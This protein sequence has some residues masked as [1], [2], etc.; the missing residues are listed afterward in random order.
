MLE[1]LDMTGRRVKICPSG[2]SVLDVSDLSPGL[3]ILRVRLA[4]G[5]IKNFKF[6]KVE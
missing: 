1:V 6:L 3:F 5:R 2:F 4:E